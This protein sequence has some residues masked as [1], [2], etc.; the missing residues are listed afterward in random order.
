MYKENRTRNIVRVGVLSAIAYILMFLKFPLLFVAPDFMSFNFADVPALI[1]SFSMGPMYGVAI[2][3][4]KNLI[5]SFATRTAGVGELS[6]FIVGSVYVIVAGLWYKRDKTLKNAYIGLILGGIAMTL[7]AV[8]SNYFIIFPLYGEVMG[9]DAIIS[10]GNKINS[11]I[12]SLFTFMIYSVVPFNLI[13][14]TLEG[15]V[16]R[17]VYKKVQNHL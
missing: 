9:L 1:G 2:Q 6:N 10:M 14:A 17:L 13:K 7:F 5:K 8:L 4:V 12:D 3:L 11:N 15:I 16:T